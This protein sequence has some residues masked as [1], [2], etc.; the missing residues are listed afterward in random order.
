MGWNHQPGF[1]T[2]QPFLQLP[3]TP[4]T[5]Y[6]KNLLHQTAFTLIRF[7]TG[8]P[9]FC[10]RHLLRQTTFTANHF[11]ARQLLRRFTPKI[12]YTLHQ[13]KAAPATQIQHP[14][15]QQPEHKQPP[16]NPSEKL[17]FVSVSWYTDP[18]ITLYQ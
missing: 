15:Q 12:F 6:S 7:C 11:N 1:Y 13:P 4:D 5:V 17:H 8:H 2:N 18:K 14:S 9:G 10:I 3:F 16:A